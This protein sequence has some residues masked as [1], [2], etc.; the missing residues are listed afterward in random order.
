[1]DNEIGVLQV[2]KKIR[3]RVK[4]Q[5]DKT[6]REYYLNEQIKAIQK[7]LGESSDPK[8]EIAEIE[9]KIKKINLSDEALDKV[10]SE[11]KKLKNMGPMSAEATVVRNYIDWI[12]SI[13]WNNN[14][15]V[16]INLRKLLKVLDK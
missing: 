13:P 11:I 14:V 3:S 2:E 4:R 15:E 6:Q 8:D 16:D 10:K 7:E 9:D 1:M 12:I 5:M